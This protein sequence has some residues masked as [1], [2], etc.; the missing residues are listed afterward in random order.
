H[1][2]GAR[3]L[4]HYV[5]LRRHDIREL[6]EQLAEL[7]LSSL[8][9]TESHVLAAIRAVLG[10]LTHISGKDGK[11]SA[12]APQP[13]FAG[14]REGRRLLDEN[15]AALL[16]P[17]PP[18]RRVRIM[19]TMPSEAATEPELLTKLLKSGMNC[20]RINCAHDGPKEWEQMI[21]NLRRA[22]KRGK[23]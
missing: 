4:L 6:Q 19:V 7:G 16:G 11:G 23:F 21:R 10:M 14:M 9:R 1:H 18:K 22:Q 2:P 17:K 15:T 12:A 3:N 5:A 13:D 8:G 20:M